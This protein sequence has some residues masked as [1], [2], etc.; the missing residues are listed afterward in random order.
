MIWKDLRITRKSCL[1][2]LLLN[3]TGSLGAECPANNQTT[4]LIVNQ[5]RLKVEIAATYSTRRC[6]LSF[7][8]SLP[9]DHGM[10]FVFGRDRIQKFWMKDT[11]IPLTIA[12]LSV[13]GLILE[14]HEMDPEEP[15]RMYISRVPARYALETNQGWFKAHNV[16][17]DDKVD[18]RLPTNLKIE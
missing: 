10:L 14:I 5:H 12:Y 16:D 3:T 7:R 2:L 9:F 4:T 1:G 13:D 15:N 17:V 6:G 8:G 18:I 11:F